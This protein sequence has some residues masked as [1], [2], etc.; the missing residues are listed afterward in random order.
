MLVNYELS[1][2]KGSIITSGLLETMYKQP[3]V[4][5]ELLLQE[6]SDGIISGMGLAERDGTVS[7]TKGIYKHKGKIYYSESDIPL[8]LKNGD[9][10]SGQKYAAVLEEGSKAA[11]Q[12][13]IQHQLII[14]AV[15]YGETIST[16]NILF[17]FRGTPSLPRAI[18]DKYEFTNDRIDLSYFKKSTIGNMPTYCPYVFRSILNKMKEIS[19]KNDML[20]Y[21]IMNN[22]QMYGY[23]TVEQMDRYIIDHSPKS[24]EYQDKKYFSDR[25]KLL[26]FFIEALNS[27]YDVP[28]KKTSD[29]DT[30][31]DPILL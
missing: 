6:Y 9:F 14:K 25:K 10:S 17:T 22:I 1:F 12:N 7:V 31:F 24:R 23:V 4:M 18:E 27:Q 11:E 20:Y 19:D 3:A 16:E 28:E 5:F 26:E 21:I 30:S 15:P 2:Q 8:T 29:R 13:I